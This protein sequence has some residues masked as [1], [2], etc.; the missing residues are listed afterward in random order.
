MYK[1]QASTDSTEAGTGD[2]TT[3]IAGTQSVINSFNVGT[4][5]SAFY[6]I[7]TRDE[8]N[9]ELDMK[10]HS[11]THNDTTAVVNSFHVVES[12]ESNSY[13]TV[14]ADVNS[15]LARLIATG[16]SVSNSVSL[17]RVVLGPSTTASS[18]GNTAFLV[19]TDV[20]STVEDIDTWSAS[21]YSC[22][23]YTSPSPRD[24]TLSRMPS[25]A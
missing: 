18:D 19:N 4:Y 10:R 7:V 13:I 24:A 17:Y 15:N 6:Y 25:S 9:Q 8:V 12:N 11:L 5:D 22:L 16:S 23:L 14:D 3:D 20:D 21:S 2:E 1:R